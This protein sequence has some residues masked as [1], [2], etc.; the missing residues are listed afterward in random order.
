MTVWIQDMTDDRAKEQ[1]TGH[2]GR[3]DGGTDH[4]MGGRRT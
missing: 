4:C 3:S 2:D 1:A